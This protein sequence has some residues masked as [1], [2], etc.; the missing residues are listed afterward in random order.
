M[1]IEPF[2]GSI[3]RLLRFQQYFFVWQRH[4]KKYR[5][6]VFY[7]GKGLHYK[8]LLTDRYNHR[9]FLVKTTNNFVEWWARVVLEWKRENHFLLDYDD[10]S[11]LRIMRDV[12]HFSTVTELCNAS[13]LYSVNLNRGEI[14]YSFFENALPFDQNEDSYVAQKASI[15]Q[16]LQANNFECRDASDDNF[17]VVNG[18]VYIVDLESLWRLE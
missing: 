11:F 6:A 7:P 10:L 12:S 5:V 14:W 15:L 4:R 16:S 2:F 17:I 8:W 9:Q 3:W 1:A 18:R 13:P